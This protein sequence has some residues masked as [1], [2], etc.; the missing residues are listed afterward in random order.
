MKIVSIYRYPVKGFSPERLSDVTLE[1]GRYFPGDRLY[2]VENGPSGF[3]PAAP[4]HQPK[5]KYLTL[6]RNAALA[7]IRTRYDD[8]TATLHA[9]CDG[10]AVAADLASSD[11]RS[12]LESFI[13][14]VVP[15]ELRGRPIILA[16][17]AGF[18][19]TDY[20]AGYVSLINLASVQAVAAMVGQPVDPL[21]FRGNLMIDGLDAWE[22]LGLVGRTL[23]SVGGAELTV[24]RRIVRCPATNVDPSTGERDTD[25]PGAL[26]RHL[27]HRDCEIYSS[28]ATG[29]RLEP[30][31]EISLVP[32]RQG[33]LALDG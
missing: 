17:P 2:A 32:A 28:V 10:D 1:A 7:R 8:A 18:R 31:D 15:Q 12:A 27:G 21:R 29:G 19:F 30:G 22:E 33:Q 26:D 13:G 3:D 25:I 6:M 20:R 11:G 16:G 23:R 24:T 5:T 4:R 14:R 9:D